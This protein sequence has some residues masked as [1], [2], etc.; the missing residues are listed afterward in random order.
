MKRAQLLL[1]AVILSACILQ[2][3]TV[4]GERGPEG[5]P[6]A[7]GLQPFVANSDG[8]IHYVGGF[9]GL[10]TMT[11]AAQLD[12]R[13]DGPQNDAAWMLA[14]IHDDTP[15][16][17]EPFEVLRRST[18]GG[19]GALNGV[20][21]RANGRDESS[22][23]FS[24]GSRPD[25]VVVRGD[26]GHVGIGTTSPVSALSVNGAVNTFD[27]DHGAIISTDNIPAYKQLDIVGRDVRIASATE[28]SGTSGSSV[29][30]FVENTTGN[31]GIG[32]STPKSTLHVSGGY[33]Q[34]PNLHNSVPPADDC[35]EETEIGRLTVVSNGIGGNDAIVGLYA[36]L[37]FDAGVQWV[38]L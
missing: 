18:A 2:T 38:K 4:P 26:S 10:G 16:F 15:D 8:S 13:T 34:V 11:P 37:G 14:R 32:T 12:V 6:G 28:P 17:G 7:N 19:T 23:T 21:L 25:A 36:C 24:V 9:V 31:V 27:G 29:R 3:E 5:S 35:D 1:L 30:V 20:E 22:L 33:V